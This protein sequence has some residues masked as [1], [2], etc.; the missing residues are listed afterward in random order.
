MARTPPF[1]V[2]VQA[3]TP[4]LFT[5]DASGKG[6]VAALNQDGSVNSP[7]NPAAQGSIVV[8]YATGEGALNAAVPDGTIISATPLAAPVLPVQV[9][10]GGTNANIMYAGAVP[11]LVAG[12]IQINIRV[13]TGLP[14]GNAAIDLIVGTAISP[15]G[16]TIWVQ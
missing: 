6:P 10:I 14:S 7:S 11:Q 15:N 16:C 9:T 1:S 4:A 12:A 8:L 2:P 3:A 5:A 13:P